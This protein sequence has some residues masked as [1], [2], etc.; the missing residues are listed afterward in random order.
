[1]DRASVSSLHTPIITGSASVADD[2]VLTILADDMP[3]KAVT[4]GV[5][6]GEQAVLLLNAGCSVAQGFLYSRPVPVGVFEKMAFGTD[7]PFPLLPV[8]PNLVQ[9]PSW[10]AWLCPTLTPPCGRQ[11]F[12]IRCVSPV[13]PRLHP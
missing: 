2:D 11:G 9:P 10:R 13:F 3:M 7:V 1:M 5:E 12:R 8:I 6:A 4:E